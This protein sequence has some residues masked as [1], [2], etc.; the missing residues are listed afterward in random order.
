MSTKYISGSRLSDVKF[1]QIIK[2]FSQGT[3]ATEIAKQTD[4]SRNSI[5]RLLAA[6]RG[7]IKNLRDEASPFEDKEIEINEN[8]FCKRRKKAKNK[9]SNKPLALGF[10]IRNGEVYT[11]VA[12]NCT[13]KQLLQIV[14]ERLGAKRTSSTEGIM[15]YDFVASRNFRESFIISRELG[16]H[17][18]EERR[19][20][21]IQQFCNN[22]KTQLNRVQ[23]LSKNTFLSH[24]R[25]CE[26]RFRYR[27]ENLYLILL[28]EFRKH[29]LKL[30]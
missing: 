11:Q 27:N 1:R 12:N 20:N 23:G 5:N 6:V 18:D 2:L 8:Y 4:V 30:S 19:I 21:D 24:I 9:N 16:K 13:A 7:R 17:T 22:A 26:F 28:K 25:E 14:N 3:E 15:T 29:P 10:V